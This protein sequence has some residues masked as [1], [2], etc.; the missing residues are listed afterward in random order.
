MARRWQPRVLQHHNAAY[1][2]FNRRYRRAP[3]FDDPLDHLQLRSL[4]RVVS[5]FFPQERTNPP[6]SS[7]FSG[8]DYASLEI[9]MAAAIAREAT[10]PTSPRIVLDSLGGSA[11]GS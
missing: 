3:W 9:R 2:A 6:L 5:Q 10:D 11:H 7:V 8:I 4:L 1:I